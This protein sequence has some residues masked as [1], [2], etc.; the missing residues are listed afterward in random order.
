MLKKFL[1]ALAIGVCSTNVF[2]QDLFI[3]FS[4]TTIST[5]EV[6][7]IASPGPNPVTVFHGSAADVD[8]AVIS[9]GPVELNVGE[10]GIGFVFARNGFD[11]GQLQNLE[12]SSSDNTAVAITSAQLLQFDT[13]NIVPNTQ[14]RFTEPA[15]AT[16][17]GDSSFSLFGTNFG[18]LPDDGNPTSN[19]LRGGAFAAFDDGFDED[20]DA[21]LLA[22]FEFSVLGGEGTSVNFDFTGGSLFQGATEVTGADA[23]F[24]GAT[25]DV[26]GVPE[27]TSAGLLALGLVGLVARRRRG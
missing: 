24:V 20:L 15:T 5:T 3:G 6:A 25:V 19:G 21:L 17:N 11:I 4:D 10:T 22:Q 27:P 2:A 1:V 18:A 13:F 14:T 8:N 23:D 9:T 16:L 12:I 7:Q 26:Q